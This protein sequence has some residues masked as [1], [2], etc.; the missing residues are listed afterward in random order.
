M[1][2]VFTGSFNKMLMLGLM[3]GNKVK[4]GIKCTWLWA[5]LRQW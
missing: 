4:A 3:C 2:V 1:T 5:M